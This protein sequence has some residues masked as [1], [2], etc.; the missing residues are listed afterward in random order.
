VANSAKCA[1]DISPSSFSCDFTLLA[2][3]RSTITL[4]SSVG[5]D[6][7][8]TI[9]I[10]GVGGESQHVGLFFNQQSDGSW[11][12][13]DD[14]RVDLCT[15]AGCAV[16]RHDIRVLDSGGHVLAQGSYTITP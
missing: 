1:I 14:T 3:F 10:D 6:D 2:P 15:R 11:R 4:P 9:Q 5:I 12:Q 8:V 13:I 16:G 7:Y